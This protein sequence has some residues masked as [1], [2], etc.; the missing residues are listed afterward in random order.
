MI[1]KT[2]GYYREDFDKEADRL[3]LEIGNGQ[4]ICILRKN[5]EPNLQAFELFETE[6]NPDWNDLISELISGSDILAKT[7]Q[8]TQCY[9]NCEE[10]LVIPDEK[11]NPSAAEDFLSLIYGEKNDFDIKHDTLSGTGLVNAYRIPKSLHDAIGRR[12]VLYRP[13]H[14]YSPILHRVL[15]REK[16]PEYLVQIHFYSKHIIVV[17]VMNGQLQLVQSFKYHSAADILYYLVTLQQQYQL[18]ESEGHLEICGMLDSDSVS[19]K[20]L[21]KLFGNISFHSVEKDKDFLDAVSLYPSYYFT[22]FYKLG[23]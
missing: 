12:F 4:V 23:V 9:Y 19:Q 14:S 22:P 15:T 7:Y 11:F 13:A 8:D 5:D 6:N 10:A 16:L 1:R 20:Q 18:P 2:I 17:Y 21:Q 3:I